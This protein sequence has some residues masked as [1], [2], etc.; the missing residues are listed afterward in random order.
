M[1]G[2][3]TGVVLGWEW[4]FVEYFLSEGN[5]SSSS[6]ATHIRVFLGFGHNKA[7]HRPSSQGKFAKIYPE[8]ASSFNSLIL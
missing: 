2:F 7:G 1:N 3:M 8:F 5:E 6:L 4:G